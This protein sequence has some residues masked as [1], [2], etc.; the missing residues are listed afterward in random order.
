M[1]GNCWWHYCF[2]RRKV[3]CCMHRFLWSVVLSQDCLRDCV[4]ISF[5]KRWVRNFC[6]KRRSMSMDNRL[7]KAD[8]GNSRYRNPIL[9]ADYSDPDAIRV[10]DDY[11]MISS[12]FCTCRR[13]KGRLADR[14]SRYQYLG[15]VPMARSVKAG[16]DDNQRPSSV[17]L[18][19]Y[20]YR[21]RSD[22][23]VCHEP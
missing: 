5:E 7:W 21:W 6:Y 15:S 16:N 19:W 13:G 23:I 4:H 20:S 2:C 8:L 17:C 3:C 11:Y 14:S 12:S 1:W 10:G 18:D 9:N 22:D